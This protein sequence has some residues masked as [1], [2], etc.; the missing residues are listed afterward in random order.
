MNALMIALRNLP[1]GSTLDLVSIYLKFTPEN[2]ESILRV[3]EQENSE[4]HAKWDLALKEYQK[5]ISHV[6]PEAVF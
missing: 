2:L 3:L 5:R 4:L 1:E 6:V